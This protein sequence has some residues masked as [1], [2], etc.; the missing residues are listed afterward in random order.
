VELN[1][2]RASIEDET[3]QLAAEKAKTEQLLEETRFQQRWRE[4]LEGEIA[5]MAARRAKA[6]PEPD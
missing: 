5:A 1:D 6:R 4:R 3:A 2:A